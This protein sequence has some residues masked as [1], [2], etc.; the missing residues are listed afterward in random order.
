MESEAAHNC[1]SGNV[2]TSGQSGKQGWAVNLKIF[3]QF[4]YRTHM[5]CLGR[6]K[7]KNRGPVRG[8][9]RPGWGKACWED[10]EVLRADLTK[11]RQTDRQTDRQTGAQRF[12]WVGLRVERWDPRDI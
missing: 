4:T 11:R 5:G 10:S 1:G 8:S 2:L 3:P 12:A 7:G 6:K 9:D